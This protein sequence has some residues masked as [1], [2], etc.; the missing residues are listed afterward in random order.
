MSKFYLTTAI[1]YANAAPHIGHAYEIIAA[2]VIARFQRLAGKDVFFLTGTDEH[3]VKVQKTAETQG[4]TPKEYVDNIADVF[5]AEWQQLNITEDRFVRTTEP[6]HYDVV[7][8]MWN[9]LLAKGDIYK[10]SYEADYCRGCELFL[11]DRDKDEDGRCLIHKT[12]PEKVSEENYFF[13]LSAYKEK[14]QAILREQEDFI[15]PVSRKQEVIN[16]LE[17]IQ[18]IS[19]SRA[20]NSV[21]WG[22]PVPNDPDQV[23]Y[24]WIDALSNYL[25]GV[26]WS[27]SEQAAQNNPYGIFW[28][29]NVQVIGKDI[30]RFHAIYWPAMLMSAELPLPKTLLV[31]GFIN[32]ADTKLS[33]STGNLVTVNDLLKRFE[34][35]TVDPIR[36][37]LMMTT[38]FG[39]DGNYTD[40]DFKLKI[41]ADLANNLGNLLNRSLSMLQK[42]CNGV[43]PEPT[44]LIKPIIEPE[45]FQTIYTDYEQYRFNDALIKI[46]NIVDTANKLI[47]DEAP[48]QLAKDNNTDRLHDVL[49]RVLNALRAVAALISPVTPQLAQ[50]MWQQLG[51]DNDITGANWHQI[52]ETALP[53]GQQTQP[54]PPILPRLESDLV[55]ADKKK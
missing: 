23:I 42:Y 9:K 11:N 13:K 49:Y 25:T 6:D 27:K 38:G 24:V 52:V 1:Y 33:K 53:A 21:S 39:Q 19:V 14:L 18:D 20:K 35:K 36:Y 31:H 44:G 12:V 32:I 4:I 45:T 41:N 26:D 37:Y 28:P 55:G 8:K 43:V 47:N 7:A 15:I 50:E 10:A 16:I 29:P 40:D 30:L 54:G 34:L 46:L 3:G 5:K 22:V 48:W 17:D 51:F 2:D